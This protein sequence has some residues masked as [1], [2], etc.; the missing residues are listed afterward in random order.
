MRVKDKSIFNKI[1]QY[2]FINTLKVITATSLSI[3]LIFSLTSCK[4]T[5]NV[6]SNTSNSQ[7][8]NSNSLDSEK[9][10][11]D[12]FA[13]DTYM[14]LTAYGSNAENAVLAAVYE[15]QR[16][17]NMFSV[18]NTESDVTRL[19]ISGAAS[20]SDE[21]S[22]LINKSLEISQKTQGAFDI[23]IYP[24]M[25][26]WGFTTQN[27]KVPSQA[28]LDEVLKKVDYNNIVI[29]GNNITLKN[30]AQI[31]FGGIAKGYTSTKV[32]ELMKENGIENAIVN[33]G[34]NVQTLG[35]KPDGSQWKVAIQS[36]DND[37]TYIGILKTNDK[38]VITS[39]GYE[40]YF[41]ENGKKYHHI[42]DS[43]TGYPSDSDLTS[44]TIIC[45][46]GT[47]AD[48]LSTSLFI[49]GKEKAA[50]FYKSTDIEFDMILVDSDKN[51]YI[52]E[53]I[54]DLFTSD[55]NVTVINK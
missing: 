17:D 15:I 7:A 47:T 3:A 39:G 43:N 27:Y 10:S 22:Y 28:E 38:A 18:G 1:K 37:D 54:K 52:S 32:I 20:V 5:T 36:P 19:N 50:Q 21:T 26:L 31:D 6:N 4:S 24:V 14:S 29:S 2:S 8:N 12:I 35:L 34:G 13:M 11:A 23:T 53:G 33:L 9:Y 55:Y 51:V 48:A 45:A 25:V 49:M 44:V 46:D 40:R 30:N 41:E 16:L 42:I